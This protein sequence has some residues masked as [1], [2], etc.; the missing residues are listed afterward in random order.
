[1]KAFLDYCKDYLTDNI[2]EYEGQRHY[3]CD[4]GY[5]L[6]EGPNCDGSLTY[7][8]AEA[9]EYLK[10][11]WDDCS[12]Y[13]EYEKFNFGTTS[14]PF[15]NPEAYMV[16]MVV[17]GVGMLWSYAVNEIGMDDNWNDKVEITA[18][19]IEK[20]KEAVSNYYTDQLL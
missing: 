8:R 9:E 7:S 6:T 13:F 2:G 19:L 5:T 20:V 4:F 3:L 17:A 18:E 1:M 11:W 10:E 16:R 12:D 15:E 14:N